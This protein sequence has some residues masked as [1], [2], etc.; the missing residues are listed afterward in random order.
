MRRLLL[1]FLLPIVAAF[2]SP[3][4]AGGLPAPDLPDPQAVIDACW[5]VS[6]EDRESPVTERWRDGHLKTALC[7]ENKIFDLL[8]TLRFGEFTINREESERD[9]KKARNALGMIYSMIYF[10]SDYCAP[11]CAPD[12]PGPDL[13]RQ[14]ALYEQLVR[15]MIWV[16]AIHTGQKESVTSPDITYRSTN[17]NEPGSTSKQFDAN[18]IVNEC[19]ATSLSDRS[20]TSS[21]RW[22][23][24]HLKTVNCLEKKVLELRDQ[25]RYRDRTLT[26]LQTRDALAAVIHGIGRFYWVIYNDSEYCRVSCGTIWHT[27]HLSHVSYVLSELIDRMITQNQEYAPKDI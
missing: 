1:L 9:L 6:K 22:S 2:S 14:T 3:T 26:R 12:T 21:E 8:D 11:N 13:I 5:A 25:L 4:A 23:E 19:W 7:L 16:T 18:A 27:Y 10:D 15:T 20:S 17:S 24:G